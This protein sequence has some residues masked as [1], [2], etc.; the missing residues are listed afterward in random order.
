MDLT[1]EELARKIDAL[2]LWRTML[3][4]NWALRPTG[5]VLPYFCTVVIDGTPWVKARLVMLEGWQTF[6][7]F[8]RTR[9]DNNF[10]FYSSPIE[11]THF[12][13]VVL[14]TGES[15][16]FRHDTGYMPRE[17]TPREDA[18]C[19]RLLW[20]VLGI[21]LRIE[22]DPKLPLRFADE[23]AMFARVEAPD[24][25][26]H[27]EPLPIPEPRQH[28][29]NI[30]FTKDSIAKAKDLPFGTDE[31]IDLDFR[32]HPSE[33]TREA[34]PRCA[35]LLVAVDG[36]TGE[37]ILFEKNSI[38][39]ESGLRG[40]WENLPQHVLERLIARGR[41]PGEIRLKSARLF[42][43]MRPLTLEIPLK[44]SLHDELPLLEQ[45]I[46]SKS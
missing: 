4:Y 8:V 26:W 22:S 11:F 33:M 34:R 12:E 13:L 32:I 36:T 10:G 27:D 14:K 19:R 25:V 24:G 46:Q 37:R 31:K 7:D 9:L 16:I 21:F 15:K 42:R 3:P 23:K 18:L 40:L 29:E 2:N 30:S 39:P 43:L 20:E 44:L 17:L 28:K 1:I 45:A 41:M 35:Y 38:H 5:T 6:H